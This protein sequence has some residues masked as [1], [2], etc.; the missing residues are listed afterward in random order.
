MA[1]GTDGLPVISHGNNT[2]VNLQVFRC[3]NT[4]CS[5]S[6]TTVTGGIDLGSSATAFQNGYINNIR[7]GDNKG[8]SVNTAGVDRLTI[9]LDGSTTLKADSTTAFVIQ[10]SA[11]SNLL[12]ADTTNGNITIGAKADATAHTFGS[13]CS[14]LLNSASGTFGGDASRDSAFSSA[15]YNGKLYVATRE[16]DRA[17][18]YRYD[19][20]TT[21]TIVTD[22]TGSLGGRIVA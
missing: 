1:I 13:T 19:G 11:G 3:G 9:G 22:Y 12:T 18:V 10:N 21:W 15:V 16:T 4:S 17:S 2:D 5:G 8:F 14:C 6:G 20:G 7:S